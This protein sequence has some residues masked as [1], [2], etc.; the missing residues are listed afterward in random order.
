MN[1]LTAQQLSASLDGALTGPSLELVVRH[2]AGCHECRDRQARFAR[3]DDVLRRLLAMDPH[4]FY[5]DDLSHRAEDIAVAI[6][7]GLPPPN[8]L[9]STPLIGE[10]DPNLPAEP[11]TPPRP[12]LGPAGQLALEAGYGRIGVRPTAS[13]QP[14]RADPEE[15]QR[16]LDALANG[17][18]DDLVELTAEGLQA[19]TALD[20]PQFDLP[21]WIK[22]RHSRAP[23][24][25][26]GPREVQ[27]LELFFEHLDERA[28]GMT[29]EA[30]DEVFRRPDAPAAAPDDAGVPSPPPTTPAWAAAGFES[31]APATD[32]SEGYAC[33][34]APAAPR[35][36]AQRRLRA[37]WLLALG[38]VS[39]LLTLILA[40][41][42]M[43]APSPNGGRER[44]V[45]ARGFR[46]PRIQFV[47]HDSSTVPTG[48][49]SALELRSA[50]VPI[51]VETSLPSA[52]VT[53]PPAPAD[54]SAPATPAHAAD[55]LAAE[56]VH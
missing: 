1:H 6:S 41:Q 44:A 29:R 56:D 51:P 5:L 21:A 55:S 48:R 49:P 16:L 23:A 46:L 32:R 11:P 52:P 43:P 53:A 22:E 42:L 20:G 18:L 15:A 25:P 26:A 13:T 24:N 37:A 30:V 3:H 27:K 4:E 35:P 39:S 50:S 17:E 8:M 9:T 31:A 33:D 54:S 36:N 40:L 28:A 34:D 7:R 47:R 45:A 10:E 19:N 14:P 12:E 2:L 38:S